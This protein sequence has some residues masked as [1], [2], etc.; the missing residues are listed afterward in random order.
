MIGY[1]K[2]YKNIHGPH[3]IIAP[4]ST[5]DN[6]MLEFNRWC[7]DIKVVIMRGTIEE[8]VGFYRSFIVF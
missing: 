1:L 7:P 6:W 4:K 2:H 8:R 3:L 5:I